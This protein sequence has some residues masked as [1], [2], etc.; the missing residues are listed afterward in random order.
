MRIVGFPSLSDRKSLEFS[1]AL[2]DCFESLNRDIRY[3]I[4][5]VGC[6]SP[7]LHVRDEL[8]NGKFTIAGAAPQQKICW[9]VTGTRNDAYAN[10]HPIVVERDK[11]AAEKGLYLHPVEHGQPADRGVDY[12][13]EQSLKQARKLHVAPVEV[14]P[15]AP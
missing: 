15:S 12:E 10:A 4:T 7:N 11:P 5:P 2:P 14:P 3:Q 9:L 1:S 6:S 8:K 13:R